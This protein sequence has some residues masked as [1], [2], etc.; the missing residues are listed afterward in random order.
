[1]RA[2]WKYLRDV[3]PDRFRGIKGAFVELMIVA[4]NY[5][6]YQT[7]VSSLGKVATNA[8]ETK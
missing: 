5:Y 6:P 8:V 7:S 1:M 4:H 3:K 2:W